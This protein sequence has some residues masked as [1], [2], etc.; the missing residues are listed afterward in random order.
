MLKHKMFLY[1]RPQRN[2]NLA[3]S[4]PLSVF[5][6]SSHL[7]FLA[8]GVTWPGV[9]WP[10]VSLPGVAAP[11]VACPGVSAQCRVE[12]LGVAIPPGVASPGNNGKID[13]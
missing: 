2:T 13:N 7:F 9:M 10:G 5:G 11:G 12:A 4:L 3:V 6:V 1:E 8:L